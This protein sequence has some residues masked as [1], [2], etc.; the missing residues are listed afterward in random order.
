GDAIITVLNDRDEA[1]KAVA[2]EA[3]GAMRY[4]RGLQALT[5]LFRYY[6]KGVIGEAALDAIARIAH[7]TS[8]PIFGGQLAGKNA[9]MRGIAIEG[10]ARLGDSAN[11]AAIDRAVAAERNDSVALAGAFATAMLANGP[12]ERLA[13]AL[14]R[15]R[16]HDQVKQ[17]LVEIAPRRTSMF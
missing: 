15:P 17:Y 2:M 9:A 11:L 13:D 5:D 7:Q 8:A 1:V 3:L 10:L 14:S 6:G 16:L 12:I 4:E